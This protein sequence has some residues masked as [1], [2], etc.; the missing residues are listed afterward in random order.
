M[1]VEYI[2]PI[3]GLLAVFGFIA[4]MWIELQQNIKEWK[5]SQDEIDAWLEQR[6]IY[7]DNKRKT[8]DKRNDVL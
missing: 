1:K 7:W 6:K 5:V 2:I 4:F 8:L 3:L